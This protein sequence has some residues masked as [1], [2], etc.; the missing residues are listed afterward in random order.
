[1]QRVSACLSIDC[2]NNHNLRCAVHLLKSQ[3]LL[4]LREKEKEP[5]IKTPNHAVHQV[6]PPTAAETQDST[7]TRRLMQS[8]TSA[9]EDSGAAVRPAEGI[10]FDEAGLGAR[11]SL[12]GTPA[13]DAIF[14]LFTFDFSDV[15][16][17]TF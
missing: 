3:A 8:D 14:V 15:G 17:R 16:A 13:V 4:S 12:A 11:R 1:M 10:G 6:G 2:R 9:A 5:K 7:H